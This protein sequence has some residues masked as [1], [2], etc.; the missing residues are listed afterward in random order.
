MESDFGKRIVGVWQVTGHRDSDTEEWKKYE[1]VRI[2]TFKDNGKGF[3]RYNNNNYININYS[4]FG[5]VLD[6]RHDD[7][8]EAL[9]ILESLTSSEMVWR[10][11]G[12]EI[13]FSRVSVRR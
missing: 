12:Y 11:G 7:G 8:N 5:K 1:D 13:K 4:I 2:Y 10:T 3:Y 9:Y 6:L